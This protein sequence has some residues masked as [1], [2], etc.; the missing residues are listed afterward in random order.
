MDVFSASVKSDGPIFRG[1]IF[2]VD[3]LPWTVLPYTF[4]SVDVIT[5]YE[6]LDGAKPSP[7]LGDGLMPSLTVLLKCDNGRE[8]K[9]REV[10][11]S[12]RR[13]Y[14]VQVGSTGTTGAECA[15]FGRSKP[16]QW[17]I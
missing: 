17:R 2:L 8:F 14:T 1:P 11:Y 6:K 7:P 9:S 16:T 10:L 4:F 15:S 13:F 3:V 12:A 5:D